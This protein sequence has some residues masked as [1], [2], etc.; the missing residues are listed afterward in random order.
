MKG[1]EMVFG[2]IR[3]R[4]WIFI[5]YLSAVIGFPTLCAVR[6]KSFNT[7]VSDTLYG[8]IF[9]TVILLLWL[10]IDS[11]K[12]FKKHLALER[13]C[14]EMEITSRRLPAADGLIDSDYCEL[15]KKLYGFIDE[16]LE[17]TAEEHSSDMQYFLRWL[18]KNYSCFGAIKKAAES[19]MP[20]PQKELLLAEH[21]L[22]E[23]IQFI[24][25]DS[26]MRKAPPERCSVDE[27][28]RISVQRLNGLFLEKKISVGMKRI[29]MEAVTDKTALSFLI[30][31]LLLNA[32]FNTESGSVKIYSSPDE[33]GRLRL[34]IEDTGEGIAHE[35]IVYFTRC[36]K[37]YKT[38]ETQGLGLFTIRRI[39][40]ACGISVT[41]ATGNEGGT[42][43]KLLIP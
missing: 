26:S 19:D 21:Y 1:I 14:K 41:Y 3:S 7:A 40:E 2:Y 24:K 6:T 12:Y 17:D 23:G 30:D 16:T 33:N 29:G 11:G 35:N 31:E 34:I 25:A 9:I 13:M 15:M 18:Q 38:D 22:R 4:I 28:V 10:I 8:I 37:I 20:I 39:S 43:V 27:L 36:G 5:M 42:S 32:L